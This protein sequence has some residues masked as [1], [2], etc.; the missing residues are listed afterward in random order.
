MDMEAACLASQ[1]SPCDATAACASYASR[2]CLSTTLR[3]AMSEAAGERH[4]RLREWHAAFKR[5][6]RE[7][8]IATTTGA[9]ATRQD[10]VE[11]SVEAIEEAVG[12]VAAM[13]VGAPPA[14]LPEVVDVA[15]TL[16]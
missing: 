5:A 1:S 15:D 6:L 3:A 2:D 16:T 11:G 10:L 9:N 12:S 14:A 4:Q 13:S 8:A 7:L